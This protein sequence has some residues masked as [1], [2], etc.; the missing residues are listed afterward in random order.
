M[1]YQVQAVHLDQVDQMAQ[2]VLLELQV[3]QEQ[4]EQPVLQAQ[5]KHQVLVVVQVHLDLQEL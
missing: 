1:D 5:V 2:A 3:H 4:A